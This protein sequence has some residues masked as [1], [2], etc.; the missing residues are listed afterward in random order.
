MDLFTTPRSPADAVSASLY[1]GCPEIAP[2]PHSPGRRSYDMFLDLSTS[3]WINREGQLQRRS[4]EIDARF[5]RN[6]AILESELNVGVQ[7]KKEHTKG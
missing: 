6:Y 5:R 7:R 4:T 1:V 2:L 3:K